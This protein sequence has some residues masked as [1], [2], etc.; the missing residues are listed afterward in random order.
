MKEL[1]DWVPWFEEL[2][3]KVGEGRRK[4]LVERAKK[5]DWAGGKCA[6][7]RARGGEG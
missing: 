2:A 3:Q 7:A 1:F 6:G 5:V 4:G